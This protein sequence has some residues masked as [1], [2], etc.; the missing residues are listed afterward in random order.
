M[1]TFGLVRMS[2]Y[3]HLLLTV[4]LHHIYDADDWRLNVQNLDHLLVNRSH[5]HRV[6]IQ[7]AADG[8]HGHGPI[9][10]SA[11]HEH[12]APRENLFLLEAHIDES[13]VL[14]GQSVIGLR[15]ILDLTVDPEDPTY[16]F[17]TLQ[18]CRGV[19]KLYEHVRTAGR[20]TV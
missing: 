9:E 6:G 15:D 8:S 1:L 17:H 4:G 3:H 19:T 14:I 12:T 16:I 11:A 5:H 2:W 10:Q 7:Q 13:C 20:D 18:T